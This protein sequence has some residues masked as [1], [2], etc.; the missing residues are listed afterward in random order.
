MISHYSQLIIN[1]YRDRETVLAVIRKLGGFEVSK[2]VKETTTHLV[3]G[4]ARRTV[5]VLAGTVKGCWLLSV[6]WVSIYHTCICR[7][8]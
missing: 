8:M 7:L 1:F 5:N 6:D 3:C 2:T 4:A